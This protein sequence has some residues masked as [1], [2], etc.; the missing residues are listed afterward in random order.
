MTKKP[1]GLTFGL[2]SSMKRLELSL[3]LRIQGC[4]LHCRLIH[5][6]VI[7]AWILDPTSRHVK[8]PDDVRH[9]LACRQA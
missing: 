7:C 3:S 6:F 9:H 8:A 2:L 1:G 5:S 4:L